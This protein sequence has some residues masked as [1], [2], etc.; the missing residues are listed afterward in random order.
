MIAV[1]AMAP[2]VDPTPMPAFAP[3]LSP[4]DVEDV[5]VSRGRVG[6]SC[7]LG[8]SATPILLA[9]EVAYGAGKD[10]RSPSTHTTSTGNATARAE[11]TVVIFD[12]RDSNLEVE[13]MSEVVRYSK[14]L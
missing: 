6:A 2:T 1:I 11:V 12:K 7:G 3:V 14:P 10:A 5:P 13:S 4:D 8:M 9:R